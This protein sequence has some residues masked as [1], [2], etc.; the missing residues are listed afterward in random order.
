MNGNF[1]EVALGRE[2]QGHA[3]KNERNTVS[4]DFYEKILIKTIISM[5][6]L[7][8]NKASLKRYYR[9]KSQ[10]RFKTL[11]DNLKRGNTVKKALTFVTLL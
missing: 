5:C 11:K 6:L 8:R 7:Y 1:F 3:S 9:S 4:Y 2:G 10:K